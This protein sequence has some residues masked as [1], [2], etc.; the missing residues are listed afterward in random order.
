M[1]LQLFA[2]ASQCG[3]GLRDLTSL[4]QGRGTRSSTSKLDRCLP[5]HT[6]VHT[7]I[8]IDFDLISSAVW[9]SRPPAYYIEMLAPSHANLKLDCSTHTESHKVLP[10]EFHVNTLLAFSLELYQ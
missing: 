4:S 10:Q 2:G 1:P 8:P 3:D 9:T 5:T 7:C 6:H